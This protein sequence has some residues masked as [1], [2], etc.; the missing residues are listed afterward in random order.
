MPF[1]GHRRSLEIGND[2]SWVRDSW[3]WTKSSTGAS[4]KFSTD[5]LIKFS[6]DTLT[7]GRCIFRHL[8]LNRLEWKLTKGNE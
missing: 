3:P 4:T 7:K 2:K 1:L 8:I 6:T 5:T